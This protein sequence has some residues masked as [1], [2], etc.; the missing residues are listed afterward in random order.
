MPQRGKAQ[1]SLPARAFLAHCNAKGI[2]RRELELYL[3]DNIPE[4]A[5]KVEEFLREG[6]RASSPVRAALIRFAEDRLDLHLDEAWFDTDWHPSA[7]ID[8]FIRS[9][10][11]YEG[12]VERACGRYFHVSR[13]T[14]TAEIRFGQVMIARES[15]GLFSFSMGAQDGIKQGS[16]PMEGFVLCH[17]NS[18]F[19]FGLDWKHNAKTMFAVLRKPREDFTVAGVRLF[20]IQSTTLAAGFAKNARA[21]AKRLVLVDYDSW[22]RQWQDGKA[23]P[24]N[25]RVWLTDSESELDVPLMFVQ[26]ED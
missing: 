1:V 17:S 23:V 20:G 5:R 9:N 3:S 10:L 19:L 24:D 15:S 18:L 7:L 22:V 4:H 16:H 25:V 6:K 26:D 12:V 21:I 11:E 13:K 14:G 8:R 2:S